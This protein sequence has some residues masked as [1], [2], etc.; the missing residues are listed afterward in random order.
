M[1]IL[2][3]LAAELGIT[4]PQLRGTLDGGDSETLSPSYIAIGDDG[5]ITFNLAG[6]GG[7]GSVD[8][9]AS[10]DS[11]PTVVAHG[12]GVIPDAILVT[13]IVDSSPAQRIIYGTLAWDAASFTVN[14]YYSPGGPVTITTPFAWVA[15]RTL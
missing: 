4:P 14:G 7:I 2:S 15:I 1:S 3:Q 10:K 6:R 13:G 9:N 5:K 11:L 12:L 8:F